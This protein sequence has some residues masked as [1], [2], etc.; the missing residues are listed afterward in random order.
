MRRI[1]LVSLASVL[2][3]AG[4]GPDS[5]APATAAATTVTATPTAT[6]T[7][8]PTVD[9]PALTTGCGIL[10]SAEVGGAFAIT[11]A[12]SVEL[13]SDHTGPTPV[14]ACLYA[15][16]SRTVTVTVSVAA[17]G[18]TVAAAL[19]EQEQGYTQVTPTALGDGAALFAQPEV[20]SVHLAVAK[21][22]GTQLRVLHLNVTETNSAR[23]L[24]LT[25]SKNKLIGL[26]TTA[27][28]RF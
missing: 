27:L 24:T 3:L 18:S 2:A 8:T 23:A 28:P 21:V 19:A 17:A 12:Q 15:K 7:P 13:N 10:T 22:H 16:D 4:C 11:G 26:A 20:G 9:A 5:N 25:N 14:F 1:M 6:P